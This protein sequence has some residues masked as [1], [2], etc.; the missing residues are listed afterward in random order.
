ML[1]APRLV[2]YLICGDSM[3]DKTDKTPEKKSIQ[4]KVAVTGIN[5]TE[6][7]DKKFLEKLQEY[8]PNVLPFMIGI[9]IDGDTVVTIGHHDPTE[10]EKKIVHI[11]CRGSPHSPHVEKISKI[12][13]ELV[14]K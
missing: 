1:Q 2:F 10:K 11:E 4:E 14:V 8:N 6:L 3:A 7:L 9:D 13:Q 5:I 12:L